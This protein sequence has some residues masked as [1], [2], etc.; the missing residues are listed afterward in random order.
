VRTRKRKFLA[1]VFRAAGLRTDED[2]PNFTTSIACTSGTGSSTFRHQ[3]LL[4]RRINQDI[5]GGGKEPLV[6]AGKRI[7]RLALEK[8]EKAGVTEVELSP[9]DL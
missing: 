5:T 3:V 8:I 7:T 4:G 2:I 6:A 1:T 9:A